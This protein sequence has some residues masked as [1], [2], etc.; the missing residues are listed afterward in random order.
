MNCH[1]SNMKKIKNTENF[2]WELLAK[3]ISNE[4]NSHENLKVESWLNTSDK[5]CEELEKIK[6]M[7]KETD[8]YFKNK[9]F[10]SNA[11]WNNVH[12]KIQSTHPERLQH[13]KIRKEAISKFYKYAAI[14]MVTLLL[15]SVTYIGFKNQL[16]PLSSQSVSAENQVVNHY[17]LPDGTVVTLN[18]NSTLHFPKHFNKSVREVT[19]A[20]EAFFDVKP[21][22]NKPF[23]INAGDVQ[24]K[25]LG[26]SFNVCAY[27]ETETVEVVVETGKVQLTR[28]TADA[29]NKNREVFLLP[30]E[31]GTLFRKSQTFNKSVNTNPNIISWKTHD[32]VFNEVPLS[33]VI[34]C[35]KKVYNIN[36]Q[37]KEPELNDLVLTAHFDKKPVDFILNVVRLTF[38]LELSE[39]NEQYTLSGRTKKQ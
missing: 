33:E 23:I 6:L 32:L 2:N 28:K 18:R 7:L 35:L 34:Q 39:E 9:K 10:N 4:T 22:A 13:K 12:S 38:N 26:T 24:V 27:P 21:N 16:S 29:E 5:N 25:V 15:G 14:L 36:I 11:A 31:K 20:G 19:I 17:V 3:Y 8:V 37:V 1:Y 30:G